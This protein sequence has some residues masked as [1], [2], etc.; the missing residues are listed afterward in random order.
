MLVGT[1]T[2][3]PLV[4][5]VDVPSTRKASNVPAG[6]LIVSV[7]AAV[8]VSDVFELMSMVIPWAETCVT[9]VKAVGQEEPEARRS[10]G[11]RNVPE[12][13]VTSMV[14]TCP[15]EGALRLPKSY[16]TIPSEPQVQWTVMLPTDMAISIVA[17]A[18]S[19]DPVALATLHVIVPSVPAYVQLAPVRSGK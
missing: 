16:E 18:E 17:A 6:T 1:A 5:V 13:S 15:K 8:H 3:I 4:D 7:P 11:G 19:V 12:L 14:A 10:A 2:I 9:M